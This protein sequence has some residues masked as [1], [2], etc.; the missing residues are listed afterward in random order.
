MEVRPPSLFQ[1]FGI[2]EHL[3]NGQVEDGELCA[4]ELHKSG[5]HNGAICRAPSSFEILIYSEVGPFLVPFS[6]G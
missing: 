3:D 5:K 2:G 4:P 1:V 6:K